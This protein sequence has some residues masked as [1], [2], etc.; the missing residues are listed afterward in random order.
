MFLCP[1]PLEQPMLYFR[2]TLVLRVG[3]RPRGEI[4]TLGTVAGNARKTE[5]KKRKKKIKEK[6]HK[7]TKPEQT[8][9]FERQEN[10]T[11]PAGHQEAFSARTQTRCAPS[12]RRFKTRALRSDWPPPERGGT[13][14]LW[15]RTAGARLLSGCFRASCSGRDGG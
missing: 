9:R 3:E 7:T 10:N 6:T 2:N 8:R 14:T 4:Y 5:K 12:P 13:L 1:L 11:P 15:R